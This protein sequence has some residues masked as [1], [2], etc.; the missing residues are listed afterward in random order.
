M[1]TEIDMVSVKK[2]KVVDLR[3]QCSELGLE[4][5]G[6]KAELIARIES[7]VNDQC[8]LLDSE[9]ADHVLTICLSIAEDGLLEAGEE[10][11][12]EPTEQE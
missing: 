10:V 1:S 11:T 8:K 7:F 4:T 2:L 5:K 6:N 3:K 12:E 9:L